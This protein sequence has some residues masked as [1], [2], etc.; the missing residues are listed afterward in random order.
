MALTLEENP[1]E[2]S[3]LLIPLPP[4]TC[5]LSSFLSCFLK[6]FLKCI[7][8]L[9]VWGFRLR[10]CQCAMCMSRETR[11]GVID[12]CKQTCEYWEL[13][14]G[15]LGELQAL[16]TPEPSLQPLLSYL[17]PLPLFLFLPSLFLSSSFLSSSSSALPPSLS[18][19]LFVVNPELLWVACEICFQILVP[20]SCSLYGFVCL[21]LF[22]FPF[23]S[24]HLGVGLGA[25]GP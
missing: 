17:P 25:W 4:P 10:V 5:L 18:L 21:C 8:L 11:S 24:W 7:L 13:N 19:P 9:C 22:C 6:T 15:P 20:C 23:P 1:L 16:L 3:F 12:G 2:A 14:L